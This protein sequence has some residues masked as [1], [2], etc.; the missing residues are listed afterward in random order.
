M[1]LRQWYVALAMAFG[2]CSLFNL[3][4]LHGNPIAEAICW[5]YE[6]YLELQSALYLRN[7]TAVCVR[8]RLF[9]SFLSL[10]S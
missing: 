4:W 3:L 9:S 7:L 6:F 1:N 5:I 2:V 8:E 10:G